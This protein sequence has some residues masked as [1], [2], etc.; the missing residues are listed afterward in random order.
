MTHPTLSPSILDVRERESAPSKRWIN[1]WKVLSTIRWFSGGECGAG[2]YR[3]PHV[4]PSKDIA[5]QKAVE[6]FARNDR[7]LKILGTPIEYLGAFPL[8]GEGK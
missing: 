6:W 5:E 2:K 7:A 1:R 4:W 8:D 3:D